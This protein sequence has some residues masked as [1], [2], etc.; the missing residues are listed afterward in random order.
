M[1]LFRLTKSDHGQFH[2]SLVDEAGEMLVQSEMYNS[3]A[4]ALNGIE[5]VRTN[6]EQESH[7]DYL[8]SKNGKF[9]FNLLAQN[10][11]I[12]ATS[13]MHETRQDCDTTA[14]ILK[15]Q[16]PKAKVVEG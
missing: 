5:S 14:T 12:V 7:Y 4:S 10:K 8:T 9:Y 13:R 16:A 11:Q 1:S 3:K 2:F 15:L 6:A